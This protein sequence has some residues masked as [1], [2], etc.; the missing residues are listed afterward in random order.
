MPASARKG[1]DTYG[2][3]ASRPDFA[4]SLFNQKAFRKAG[5]RQG[6][7]GR[8]AG[9]QQ[10]VISA[11]SLPV[12]RCWAT[13]VDFFSPGRVLRVGRLVLNHQLVAQR[14]SSGLAIVLMVIPALDR[15]EILL[16]SSWYMS[17]ERFGVQR[18]L[19]EVRE[20]TRMLFCDS[21]RARQP[22]TRICRSSLVT[23][24]RGRGARVLGL[25]WG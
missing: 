15:H 13:V 3:G 7:R 14:K 23:S 2:A 21:F 12:M 25:I 6:V 11:G 18:G 22:S 16:E 5:R 24:P 4:E 10:L 8:A 20:W 19:I 1:T 9:W 17:R